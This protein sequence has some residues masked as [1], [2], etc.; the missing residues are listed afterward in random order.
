MRARGEG[1]ARARRPD[2]A[3]DRH[4]PT[5]PR[6]EEL[7]A[8][9]EAAEA[10]GRFDEAA[11]LY[12]RCLAIDP[13]RFGRRLQPRQLPAE[14]TGRQRGSGARL[15]PRHQA[16]PGICRGLVQLRRPAA[17][18]GHADSGAAAPDQGASRVD[19]DYADAVY[20]L[21]AARISRPAKLDDARALVGALSRAR[22]QL[23]MGAAARR[24][25]SSSSTSQLAPS[26]RRL[27]GRWR[28]LPVRRP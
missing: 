1:L 20:N 6:C 12:R 17:E 22:P 27:T 21:A 8:E 14:P 3:A 28:P 7:F 15:Y 9:A 13:A 19:P 2:A 11:E 24:A 18:R 23:G 26:Q 4:A 5:M 16:R 10:D 25:A